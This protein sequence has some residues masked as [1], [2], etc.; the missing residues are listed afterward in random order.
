MVVS[1][2]AVAFLCFSRNGEMEGCG[3][4]GGGGGGPDAVRMDMKKD[5]RLQDL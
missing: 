5:W 2:P 1:L 4:G 3:G